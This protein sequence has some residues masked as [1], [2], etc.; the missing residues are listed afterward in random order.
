MTKMKQ[1]QSKA[2][3]S[4]EFRGHML[5]TFC[6]CGDTAAAHCRKCGKQVVVDCS[7]PPHGIDIAGEAVALNCEGE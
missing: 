1:L 5:S 2:I 6:V 7:P 4:A 3:K